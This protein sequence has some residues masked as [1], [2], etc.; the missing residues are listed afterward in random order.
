MNDESI[1]QWPISARTFHDHCLIKADG[2]RICSK[3]KGRWLSC[4]W[5]ILLLL[6]LLLLSTVHIYICQVDRIWLI[7][8]SYVSLCSVCFDWTG[9]L[10]CV[11][12]YLTHTHKT[13]I[14]ALLKMSGPAKVLDPAF[15]G[16][17]QKPYA[18]QQHNYF[19]ISIRFSLCLD[20]M[21]RMLS[22]TFL[23]RNWDLE[24][25]EFRGGSCAQNRAW[26]VLYGRHLHCLAGFELSLACSTC[27][28]S[29]CY[30]HSFTF[31][32]CFIFNL[33]RRHRTKEVLICLTYTSG[34]V[35]TQVR[36]LFF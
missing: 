32:L 27:V 5:D 26:K 24:N 34:L 2:C 7:I 36:C 12:L 17:G 3:K 22:L 31:V 29:F 25:R 18:F 33:R 28:P 13:R 6:L 14:W 1:S 20:C 23:Q 30:Y 15:Q 35:K 8:F 9:S 4:C 21:M 19:L 16:A 11:V 10:A